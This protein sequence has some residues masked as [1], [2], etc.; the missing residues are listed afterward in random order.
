[1]PPFRLASGFR[2][3]AAIVWLGWVLLGLLMNVRAASPTAILLSAY[4]LQE[5]CEPGTV[6]GTLTAADKDAGD[7]HTYEL[8]SGSDSADNGGFSIAGDQLL[9]PYGIAV[10]G[11]N[12]DFETDPR[13]FSV[14]VRVKDGSMDTFEQAL[15]IHMID[16]RSEDVD[17]DDLTEADEEDIYGTSDLTY[18]SDW[19]GISDGIEVLAET[20]PM[21]S[22]SW[23]DYPLLG[24]GDNRLGELKGPGESQVVSISTAQNHSLSLRSDGSVAAWAGRNRCGQTTIPAGL[25]PV[26]AVAAG[27][28]Y[29]ENDSAFSLVLKSDGTVV[30]W[31]CNTDGQTDVPEGLNGVV[32]IAAGRAHCLALKGDGTVV[33]WGYFLHGET[34]VPEG[35]SG[36]VAVA[37]GGYHSLALKSD[38][39]VVTWGSN[40]NGSHWE[41]VAA[42]VGL[43]DVV[44]VSAGRF[45]SLALKSDG[46]VV[47]WGYGPFGQTDVPIGLT[48]VVAISA[49]GFHS[50]ALKNDGSVVC[51]GLNTEGQSAVPSSAQDHVK[52]IS[53]GIFHSLAMRRTQGFPEI[54]SVRSLST[55]LGVEVAHQ[56]NVA[57]A[58][59]VHYSASGLPEGL[60]LDEAGGLISGQVTTAVRQSVRIQVDTDQGV[61]TQ[62]LRVEIHVGSPP[63]T[64]ELSPPEVVENALGGGA[65]GELTAMDPDAGDSHTFELVSGEGAVDNSRFQIMLGNQLVLKDDLDRDFESSDQPFLIRVRVRDNFLNSHE[66]VLHIQLLDDLTE[67]ADGDGLSE[68]AEEVHGTSDLTYDSDGDGFGDGYEVKHGT[69]ASE[70]SSF[71]DGTMLVAWGKNES[72]QST[73]PVDMGEIIG[74]A[75]GGTH[76]M[77]LRFDGSVVAWG[78]NEQGQSDVPVGL[79]GVVAIAAGKYHSVA[80]TRSGEMAAWGGND[81]SQ[82]VVEEGLSNVIAIAAGAFHSLALLRDGSVRAWGRNEA[83]QTNVPENLSGVIAI[84]AGETSSFAVRSDGSVVAWGSALEGGAELSEFGNVVGVSAGGTHWLILSESGRM[85]AWDDSGLIEGLLPD[86]L[87]NITEIASGALHHCVLGQDGSAT[88]WGSDSFGQTAPPLE[89]R[90]LKRIAAGEF[91]CVALRGNADFPHISNFEIKAKPGDVVSQSVIVSGAT[92]LHFEAMGL[93]AGLTMDPN[94]GAIS[95]TIVDGEKRCVRVMVDTPAGLITKIVYINTADGKPP[96]DI[97]LVSSPVIENS[98]GGTVVGLLSAEDS[99]AEDTHVFELVADSGSLDNRYFSINE[100]QLLIRPGFDKDF[101]AEPGSLSIRVLATD[102]SGNSFGKFFTIPFVDDRQEDADLDGV[103]EQRE[104]DVFGFSDVVPYDYVTADSD[105][106][107][108]SNLIEHAFNLNPLIPDG[109][110][111]LAGP[112]S[113]SGLPLI[114]TIQDTQGRSILRIEFLRRIGSELDYRPEFAYGVSP[115]DWEMATEPLITT[116]IDDSWERCVIDDAPNAAGAPT[117]FGRVGVT[118]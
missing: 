64:I 46:K 7:S 95:G 96:T 3:P 48:E 97:Q 108:V 49:G 10:N 33:G 13:V 73:E 11:V 115:L 17:G 20:S 2:V 91:H 87:E 74:V 102:A 59:P 1:M 65:V 104:E 107:G 37:A 35:L 31:G 79:S 8:V 63:T 99:D 32:A 84:A 9:A 98:P 80:L 18:D 111:Y 16:D 22:S 71:P 114:R 76:S 28:D 15:T 116:P 118:P 66:E 117:R 47:G 29:W 27:G 82:C 36:I 25:G 39:S 61:L 55:A 14:R 110:R 56:L 4:T 57:N 89:A 43:T 30:A 106:D 19:D 21:N 53:A 45:H 60:T 101:E 88:C 42:P 92:S 83:G 40:F 51:W 70:S 100:N 94:S 12:V 5:N 112:E 6:V 23:P 109:D 85:A 24:W 58:I 62:I 75:A 93:P 67:D 90:D 68:E 52:L 72:G 44:A 86:G 69:F 105:Q 38:G 34:A 54:T 81:Y 113:T 26:I 103:S 77:A 78:G 50:M 41:T